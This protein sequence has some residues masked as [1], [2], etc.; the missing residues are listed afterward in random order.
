MT[1]LKRNKKKVSERHYTT[2]TTTTNQKGNDVGAMGGGSAVSL[3]QF[4]R[5]HQIMQSFLRMDALPSPIRSIFR[6]ILCFL[7]YCYYIAILLTFLIVALFLLRLFIELFILRLFTDNE[8][9]INKIDDNY[10]YDYYYN[11]ISTIPAAIRTNNKIAD[12]NANADDDDDDA[13]FSVNFNINF[14]NP[15]IVILAGPHKTASTT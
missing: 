10:D 13:D 1:A 6:F 7:L 3:W 14:N 2:T 8:S 12:V 15:Q 4:V 5:S 11:S 9:I